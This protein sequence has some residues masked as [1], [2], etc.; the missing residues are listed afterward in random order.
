MRSEKEERKYQELRASLQMVD[1][2]LG[3]ITQLDQADNEEELE[4]ILPGLLGSMG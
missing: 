1:V 4:Q 2:I 3:Y